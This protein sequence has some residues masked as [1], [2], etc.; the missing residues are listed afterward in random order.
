MAKFQNNYGYF[1]N[2]GREYVITRPDT[3]KPWVNV[4]SNG[5]YG[6]VISQAGGGFS[7]SGHSNFNRLTRWHQDMV[8]DNWG[9]FLYLRDADSGHIWSPSF[10]PVKNPAADY[11]CR[12]GI[13]YSVFTAQ[14]QDIKSEWTLFAAENDPL[15]IWILHLTNTGNTQ[16]R[17]QVYSYLEWCLGF[18][19]DSH[20]E[21]HKA[22]IETCYDDQHRLLTAEKRLWEVA[23]EKGRHW[24]RDWPFIAFHAASDPVS[25]YDGDKEAFIGNYGD[26]RT[27]AAVSRGKSH[28]S[29]GKW[30]DA[31]GSLNVNL[32]IAPQQ[33]HETVFVLG[34][35]KMR[36]EAL[37]LLKKYLTPSAAHYEL[38]QVRS[39]W[40]KRLSACH[41]ETPDDA[42]DFMTNTWLK[43]QTISCRLWGRA[44]YYQQSGAYGFR[45][46][47]QDSLI[48]L[49]LDPSGT[50]KQILL[51]AAHQFKDGSVY[52]WWHPFTETGLHNNVSDNLLWLP[53]VITEYIKE[54]GDYALL[55]EKI[56]FVD[57]S[58]PTPLW[59]HCRRALKRALKWRSKRGLPLIGDHD[60][61]DGLNAV[62]NE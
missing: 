27:P 29:E 33:S 22:F 43:Y 28:N 59:D 24:N 21:F 50:K 38:G 56:P 37:A 61:N 30:G 57:D 23:D 18:A 45:D 3:P 6:F 35:S 34:L 54:T 5:E 19:P 8:Q 31:I 52:H 55:D 42:F 12:H 17:L 51:H 44:A 62:G 11:E 15:E 36:V 60:W 7:W 47:L 40:S 9:K 32:E 49:P 4:I 10:Q 58:T 48:F 16:R 53:F 14:Y 39:S 13:G 41:V 26:L 1:T 25:S 46:Q 20:R 2:D